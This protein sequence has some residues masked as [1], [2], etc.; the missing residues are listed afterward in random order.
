M[1][2]LTLDQNRAKRQLLH[3][4]IYSLVSFET[5]VFIKMHIYDVCPVIHD[6]IKQKSEQLKKNTILSNIKV[7]RNWMK[8]DRGKFFNVKP[9]FP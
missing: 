8:N 2:C 4:A 5:I 6:T 9:K 1:L 3:C 7:C